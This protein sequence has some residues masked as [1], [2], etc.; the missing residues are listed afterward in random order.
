MAQ[1]IG[2]VLA[3]GLGRRLGKPKGDVVLGGS[4][5]ADRAAR[6]AAA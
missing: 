2:V 1:R 6:Y 4:T 5:L 3:G